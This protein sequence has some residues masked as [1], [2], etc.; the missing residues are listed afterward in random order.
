MVLVD[1][2]QFFSLL[3]KSLRTN[4]NPEDFYNAVLNLENFTFLEIISSFLYKN[5]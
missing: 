4:T 1:H 3:D 5:Y 2:N